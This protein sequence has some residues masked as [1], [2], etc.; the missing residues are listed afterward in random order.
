MPLPC[1]V[2]AALIDSAGI[3]ATHHFRWHEETD[4]LNGW[5]VPGATSTWQ[6]T[7]TTFAGAG[8]G[9]DAAE[10]MRLPPI[11]ETVRRRPPVPA[12][13][14]R[15]LR[16]SALLRALAEQLEHEDLD[17]LDREDLDD[18]GGRR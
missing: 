2:C 6:Q 17:E 7:V 13:A 3:S 16:G 10:T 11:T 5:T 8:A 15:E 12:A 18:D 9:A 4:S 14:V 1:P